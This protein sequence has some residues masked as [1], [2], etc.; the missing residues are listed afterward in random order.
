MV[1]PS[2]MIG[3]P[4]RVFPPWDVLS[5]LKTAATGQDGGGFLGAKDFIDTFQSISSRKDDSACPAPH[6]GV[7]ELSLRNS[8][9]CR[10]GLKGDKGGRL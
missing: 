9:E 4:S 6:D 1:Y 7:V 8:S 3:Y 10:Y 5:S 2:R